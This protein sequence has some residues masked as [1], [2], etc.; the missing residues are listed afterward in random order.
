[1]TSDEQKL[2]LSLAAKSR[3]KDEFLRRFRQSNDGAKLTSELLNEAIAS[4][5]ADDVE[6]AL[7]VG[8]SFGFTDQHLTALKLLE[9]VDWHA[10]HED[11]VSALD[12]LK[13]GSAV[14]ALYHATQWG[15]EYLKFDKSRALAVKAIWALGKIEGAA[16]EDK[17]RQ[18]AK[19][20]NPILRENAEKQ[21]ERRRN[22]D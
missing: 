9:S 8:F 2:I 7:L 14:E 15:P 5:D 16:A 13:S 3:H 17:L 18:L 22:K 11:V 4:R 20:E 19:E 1:M 12:D 10:R 6:M 21:I